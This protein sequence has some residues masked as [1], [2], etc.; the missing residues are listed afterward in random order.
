MQ[1]QHETY[2]AQRTRAIDSDDKKIFLYHASAEDKSSAPS[3]ADSDQKVKTDSLVQRA[4][5]S[6]N[7]GNQI[8]A[9]ITE[10]LP[11]NERQYCSISVALH[12][13]TA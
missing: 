1:N 2:R 6:E 9:K 7:N 12:S 11:M 5:G 8:L 13:G 4:I 3:D 10:P